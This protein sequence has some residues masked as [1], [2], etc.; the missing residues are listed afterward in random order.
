VVVPKSIEASA[1]IQ[2]ESIKGG[3]LFQAVSCESFFD[4]IK[5]IEK[6]DQPLFHRGKCP[7]P[8]TIHQAFIPGLCVEIISQKPL[9]KLLLFPINSPCAFVH[10]LDNYFLAKKLPVRHVLLTS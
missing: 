2:G 3:C 5:Q 4:G 7:V 10:M 1:V 9:D 6:A 8:E